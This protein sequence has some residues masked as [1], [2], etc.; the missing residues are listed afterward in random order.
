MKILMVCGGG[1]SSSALV[2]RMR[3]YA[4]EHGLTDCTIEYGG[5][6]EIERAS[7]DADVVMIAP[8]ISYGIPEK[9][10]RLENG[11]P[12]VYMPGLDY[13]RANCEHLFQ[14]AYEAVNDTRTEG[15]DPT[16]NE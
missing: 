9:D 4:Q 2:R 12:I 5:A 13:G 10:G 3:Q 7:R 14:L 6:F 15:Q 11:T 8:Q 1:F 16:Q